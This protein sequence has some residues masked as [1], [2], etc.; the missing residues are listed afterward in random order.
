MV[1]H[2]VDNMSLEV[3]PQFLRCC[4][5]CKSKL[6]YLWVSCFCSFKCSTGVVYRFLHFSSSLTNAELTAYGVTAKYRYNS[7]PNT[8]GLNNRVVVRYAF[9]SWKALWQSSVHF[10]AFLRTLKNGK[11]LSVALETYLLRAATR[12]VSD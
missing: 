10:N 8:D 2:D 9:R 3:V 7:S 6:F 4:D 12:P 11:H 5:Q 1:R